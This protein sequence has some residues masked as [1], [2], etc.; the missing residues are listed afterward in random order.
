MQ[1]D[2]D[3]LALAL[4]DIVDR[5]CRVEAVLVH[6]RLEV[7][8]VLLLQHKRVE[9]VLVVTYILDMCDRELDPDLEREGKP[10]D[11]RRSDEQLLVGEDMGLAIFSLERLELLVR[12][13]FFVFRGGYLHDAHLARLLV[14]DRDQNELILR[15]GFVAATIAVLITVFAV[16]EYLVLLSS[17][18]RHIVVGQRATEGLGIDHD[19]T[20]DLVFG[21]NLLLLNILSRVSVIQ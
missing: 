7:C 19:T 9:G 20:F 21:D 13:L 16:L 2:V 5:H 3:A 15:F 18:V 1:D 8:L 12:N 11:D 17:Y 10:Q 6:K 14:L 4:N